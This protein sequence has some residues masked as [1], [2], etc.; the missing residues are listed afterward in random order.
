MFMHVGIEKAGPG[1]SLYGV[2]AT[3]V[4]VDAQSFRPIAIHP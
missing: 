4:F 3:G 1:G 2:A